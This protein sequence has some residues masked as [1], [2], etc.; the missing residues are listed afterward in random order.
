VRFGISESSVHHTT[1]A[2]EVQP[3]AVN[4]LLLR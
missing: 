3:G 2:T 4:E 1:V